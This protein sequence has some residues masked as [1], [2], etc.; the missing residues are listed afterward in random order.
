MGRDYAY[1]SLMGA[2]VRQPEEQTTPNSKRYLDVSLSGET[3]SHDKNIPWYMTVC[4][5]GSWLKLL[6]HL[7][8]GAVVLATG[9]LE[10]WSAD[11][12]TMTR[13]IPDRFE[14]IHGYPPQMM[15]E[16]KSGGYRFPGGINSTTLI[17]NLTKDSEIREIGGQ[18]LTKLSLAVSPDPQAPI[19]AQLD[20]WNSLGRPL[21]RGAR[22][23][24]T[25]AVSQDRWIDAN[26]RNRSSLTL[27][28][29]RLEELE[30]IT[31]ISAKDPFQ[32]DPILGQM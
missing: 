8:A 21:L 7:R 4:L 14:L 5:A 32:N 3:P 12:N 6:P 28:V 15:L 18:H 10:Q 17:G 30:R 2:I 11:Q 27:D 16:D 29:I 24:A 20:H 19:Y 1:C 26:K 13:V 9:H 22:L 23:M 31:T 25:G